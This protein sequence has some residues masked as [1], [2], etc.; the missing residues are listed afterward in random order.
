M[1]TNKTPVID[2][3]IALKIREKLKKDIMVHAR[4]ETARIKRTNLYKSSLKP[5]NKIIDLSE[6]IQYLEA[7]LEILTEK[8]FEL[9]EEL[10]QLSMEL[11][12][13]YLKSDMLLVY[14][15]DSEHEMRV[16]VN[17]D[18]LP[19]LKSLLV[20]NEEFKDKAYS[21]TE[22]INEIVRLHNDYDRD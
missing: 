16:V 22:L 15:D 9:N 19:D 10:E 11:S 8:Y 3:A 6:Q 20:Y 4:K 18:C 17:D 1:N 7:R 12:D 13:K 2:E 21:E 5:F 14:F